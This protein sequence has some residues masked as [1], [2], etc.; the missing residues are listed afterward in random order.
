M[1]I[2][3][4]VRRPLPR[5]VATETGAR[6]A[7]EGVHNT[8]APTIKVVML[9]LL[10]IVP[11][12]TGHLCAALQQTSGVLVTLA[13]IT[14]SHDREFFEKMAVRNN[15]GV[16]DLVSRLGG[17][18]APLRRALKLAESLINMGAWLFRFAASPPDVVHVQFVPL[19]NYG[20][21]FEL[22]FLRI[23]RALGIKVVYTVHNVLPQDSGNRYRALFEQLYRHADVL[24]CHDSRAMDR[25]VAEFGVP[26]DRIAIVPH[27]PLFDGS[28]PIAQLRDR[29]SLGFAPGE[30]VVLWQGILRPYKGISFLLKAWVRVCRASSG[31]RL[32]IVGG[33]DA[34]LAAGVEE[35]V[36]LLGIQSSVRLDFR[37]VPIDELAGFYEA[38][39]ILVYPYSEITTSGALMTGIAHGKPIVATNLPAFQEILTDGH[40][41][42]LVP[43]GD[44]D[45]LATSLLRLIRDADLRRRMGEHVRQTYSARARWREIAMTTAECYKKVL[46]RSTIGASTRRRA[47]ASPTA[48]ESTNA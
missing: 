24:I 42:L 33:G 22:W 38:A 47:S 45:A 30:C 13:S 26:P 21:S 6:T 35:D 28:P 48:S 19:L 17:M 3:Q 12:Y 46:S 8:S 25:L 2:A 40:D 37:Y 36:R 15:P 27:G 11:Y 16:F 31:V 18:A 44:V 34:S 32:A 43:F 1:L 9:D 39:D 20:L 14:Y 29:T 7:M 41:A 23:V 4:W 5:R 10:S